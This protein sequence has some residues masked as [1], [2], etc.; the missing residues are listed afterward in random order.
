GRRGWS[1]WRRGSGC[2][3]HNR[4][5]SALAEDGKR[6]R[7]EHEERGQ[8]PRG[9]RED[10]GTG[11]RAER[12]LAPTATV[13][14]ADVPFALLEEDDHQHHDADEHVERGN[15]IVENHG[16]IR[17]PDYTVAGRLPRTICAKLLTSRL[18][19]PTSA[20]STSAS[21]ISSRMLSGLTLP[22]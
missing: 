19:P 18:A 16:C 3:A 6:H 17:N 4:R 14:R 8:H 20:P 15:Q 22:P 2:S 7:G 10:R 1:R 12:R 21:A 9:L 13:H 5:R 11:A